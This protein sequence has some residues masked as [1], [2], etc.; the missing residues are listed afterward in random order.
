MGMTE[1]ELNSIKVPTVIVPGNDNTHSSKSGR[2]A[3]QMIKGSELHELPITD[4]DV[5]LL[6]WADWSH[7]EPEIA[8]TFIDFLRRNERAAA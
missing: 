6:A 2:I 1:A 8:A 7:L 3:H 4:Q 5:D